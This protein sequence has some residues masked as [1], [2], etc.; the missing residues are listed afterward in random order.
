MTR[1]TLASIRAITATGALCSLALA[2]PAQASLT[3]SVHVT[4]VSG[5][6]GTSTVTVDLDH[7]GI[8]KFRWYELYDSPCAFEAT[9]KDPDDASDERGSWYRAC[10]NYRR[11]SEKIVRFKDNPRYFVRGLSV[12][13]NGKKNHRLKGLKIWAAKLPA[14]N[15][16]VDELTVTSKKERTNCKNWHGPVYCPDDQ[17]ASGVQLRMKDDSIVGVALECRRRE[18]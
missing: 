1:H 17:V 14:G 18:P 6:G 7:R 9:G 13:T 5:Y 10:D 12:C 11:D 8:T 3:G 16:V 2:T 4:D 15:G